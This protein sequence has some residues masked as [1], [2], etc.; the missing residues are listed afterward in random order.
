MAADMISFLQYFF[1][2][3]VESRESEFS[4][5]LEVYKFQNKFF[6]KTDDVHQSGGWAENLYNNAFRKFNF[7]VGTGHRPVHSVLILGLA[8]GTLV[9]LLNKIY[10]DINITGVDID[11]VM[12]DLGRKY[13]RLDEYINLTIEIADAFEYVNHVKEQF[14]LVIV[15]LFKRD[16]VQVK[17]GDIDFLNDELL[18]TNPGGYVMINC[19]YLPEFKKETDAYLKF[20]KS[21]EKNGVFK[22][23]D[24]FQNFG[25]KV[26]LLR[27]EG[28]I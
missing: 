17:S 20:L 13:F 28:K 23:Q 4:G 22:I 15:D 24:V 27:K 6:I 8:G 14:D 16:K 26:L 5:R 10:P 21:E 18:A 9:E 11:L 1:P 3:L 2:Q 7:S 12:V 19:L 25:N